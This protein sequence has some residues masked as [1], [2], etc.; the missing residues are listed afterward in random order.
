MIPGGFMLVL[1]IVIAVSG[2]VQSLDALAAI[3]FAGIGLVFFAV[4]LLSGSGERW[5]A[6]LP[7][8][9]LVLFALFVFTGG[10]GDGN[11]DGLVQW[12]PALVVVV[13]VILAWRALTASSVTDA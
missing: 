11:R 8:S 10:G 9:I 13:G 6:L 12:W 5:W 4:Y 1:G 2:S 7:G 3:L